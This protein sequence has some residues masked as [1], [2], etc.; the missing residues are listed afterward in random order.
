VKPLIK[1]LKQDGFIECIYALARFRAAE[2]APT[3]I[4]VASERDLFNLEVHQ[5]LEYILRVKFRVQRVDKKVYKIGQFPEAGTKNYP[6]IHKLIWQHWIKVG[7]EYAKRHF[8]E[9]YPQWKT[10]LRDKPNAHSLH[11]SLLKKMLVGGVA[12]IPHMMT[13]IEDGDVDLIQAVSRLTNEQQLKNYPASKCFRWWN[14]NKKK[15]IIFKAE[16][17]DPNNVVKRDESDLK[18]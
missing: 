9:Y 18:K 1:T 8:D 2:A 4:E 5:C 12:V 11:K 7:D 10:A 15:W 13:K 14:D 3:I 6:E 16:G 17:E